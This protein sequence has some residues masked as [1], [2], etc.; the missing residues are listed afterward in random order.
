MNK[1]IKIFKELAGFIHNVFEKQY[2]IGEFLLKFET[3]T[4]KLPKK[5]ISNDTKNMN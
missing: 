3:S 4:A 2:L 1:I 5:R